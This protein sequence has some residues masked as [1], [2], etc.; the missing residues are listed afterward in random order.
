MSCSSLATSSS[1]CNQIR[2]MNTGAQVAML[3]WTVDTAVDVFMEA[4][5]SSREGVVPD[6][7]G[8]LTHNSWKANRE[9]TSKY[10]TSN[11]LVTCEPGISNPKF[12]EGVERGSPTASEKKLLFTLDLHDDELLGWVEDDVRPH[13]PRP[14]NV[15]TERGW[16]F[17][18]PRDPVPLQLF[19]QSQQRLLPVSRANLLQFEGGISANFASRR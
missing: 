14:T 8:S 2:M 18:G 13:R 4:K 5:E 10:I 7:V 9:T 12:D 19:L 3:F 11:E 6:L 16:S 15:C 17:R 1:S